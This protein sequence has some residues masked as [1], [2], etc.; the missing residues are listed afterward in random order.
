MEINVSP[1]G[2]IRSDDHEKHKEM[3]LHTLLEEKCI[4]SAMEELN[5]Q[6][7]TK[8]KHARNMP[9]IMSLADEKYHFMCKHLGAVGLVSTDSNAEKFTQLRQGYRHGLDFLSK[10]ASHEDNEM[11]LSALVESLQKAGSEFMMTNNVY[12]I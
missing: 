8:I 2:P 12:L 10:A 7:V 4:Y 6:G 9:A 11:E 1:Y 5:I 3:I